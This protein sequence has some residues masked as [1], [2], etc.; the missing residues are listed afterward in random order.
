MQVVF[1]ILLVALAVIV[2]FLCFKKLFSKKEAA[3]A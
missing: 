1:A 3:Q 2:A